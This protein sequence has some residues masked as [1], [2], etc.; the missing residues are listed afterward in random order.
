MAPL[1][2]KLLVPPIVVD[3]FKVMTPLAVPEPIESVRA[4]VPAPVPARVNALAIAL[5][6]RSNVPPLVVTL[7]VPKGPEVTVP[8][9]GVEDAPAVRVPPVIVVPPL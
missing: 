7:E 3:P 9:V 8:V 2:E 6:C 4:Y 5:P 1:S